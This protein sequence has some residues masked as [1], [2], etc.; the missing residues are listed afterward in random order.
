MGT[1]KNPQSAVELL[2]PSYA[3]EVE[4]KIK[5]GFVPEKAVEQVFH[6]HELLKRTTKF[7]SFFKKLKNSFPD[8][9]PVVPSWQIKEAANHLLSQGDEKEFLEDIS[10]PE[11]Y[12]RSLNA[13][14]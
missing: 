5:A 6:S 11:E 14:V 7:W 3:K 2:L 4:Q 1:R 9:F 12:Q 8:I 10:S 13:L